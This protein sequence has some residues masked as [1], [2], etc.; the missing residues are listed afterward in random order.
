MDKEDMVHIYNRILL[1]HEKEW[2]QV[3]CRDMDG[4]RVCY[5]EWSKSEREKQVIY[6]KIYVESR[7]MVKMN[8]F[9]DQ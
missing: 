4:P 8:L 5:T 1:S 9:V 6:L 3:I 7:K 2:I